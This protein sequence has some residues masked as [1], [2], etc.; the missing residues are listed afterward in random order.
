MMTW[1]SK[2]TLIMAAATGAVLALCASRV[3]RPECRIWATAFRAGEVRC[4][5]AAVQTPA[6]EVRASP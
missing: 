4:T 3:L 5:S 2:G 1:Q 6:R